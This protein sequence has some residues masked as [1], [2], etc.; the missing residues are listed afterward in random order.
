MQ[1]QCERGKEF[2]E[3]WERVYERVCRKGGEGEN[4]VIKIQCQK[5]TWTHKRKDRQ[6]QKNDTRVCSLEQTRG[7]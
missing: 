4:V 6:H 5:Q 3:K 1:Y 2:E 7:F